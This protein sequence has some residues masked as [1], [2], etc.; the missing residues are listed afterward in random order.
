MR[1]ASSGS[2]LAN[3]KTEGR[4]PKETRNP[5]A[6]ISNALAPVWPAGA[7]GVFTNSG[8]SVQV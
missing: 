8:L 4:N 2:K 6:E 3:P 1:G 7:V 5:K